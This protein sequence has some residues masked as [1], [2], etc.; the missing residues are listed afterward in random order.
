M[1]YEFTPNLNTS[2]S[3]ALSS[4]RSSGIR[5]LEQVRALSPLPTDAGF[6]IDA[7]IGRVGR[8]RLPFVSALIDA[9]LVKPLPNWLQILRL[10]FDNVNDVGAAKQTME[11]DVQYDRALQDIKRQG[12]PIYGTWEAF[13]FGS[14]FLSVAE[15]ANYPVETNRAE[16]ATRNVN[17]SIEYQ[18]INGLPFNIDGETAPGILT[19]PA[20]TY[21]Y[22]G[23]KTLAAQTGEELKSTVLG[24]VDKAVAKNKY[25]PYAWVVGTVGSNRLNDDYKTG[26][27]TATTT[28][29]Q[30]L[31]EMVFDGRPLQIIPADLMPAD[32]SALI[33]MTSD[34]IDVV[35]GQGPQNYSWETNNGPFSAVESMVLACT[36]VRVHQDYNGDTGIVVGHTGL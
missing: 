33:Q 17:Y 2:H 35:V 31:T 25:G 30:R 24:M 14:R 28:I 20:I 16:Q 7:A 19:N 5:S 29:R 10:A 1:P 27:N 32:Y 34:V 26:A 9:G 12:I 4:L 23:N 8:Q 3:R 22:T 15:G 21:D 11:F 18:G 13:S 6:E 36:I